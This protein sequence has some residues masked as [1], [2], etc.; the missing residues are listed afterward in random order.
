MTDTYT[1]AVTPAKAGIQTIDDIPTQW[2]NTP[3][4]AL[5][6]TRRFDD[7]LDSGL[8]RNDGVVGFAS[9]GTR[10]DRCLQLCKAH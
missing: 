10:F 5:A 9:C 3:R 8:R 2:D 6:A 1:A 4:T 7:K